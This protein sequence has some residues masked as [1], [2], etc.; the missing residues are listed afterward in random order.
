MT[1]EEKVTN[2]WL[3]ANKGSPLKDFLTDKEI[4][5]AIDILVGQWSARCKKPIGYLS[6]YYGDD[7]QSLGYIFWETN[8]GGN[9][10]PVYK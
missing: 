2:A 8:P 5:E 3:E 9:S 1:F 7:N 10:F 4:F 6:S